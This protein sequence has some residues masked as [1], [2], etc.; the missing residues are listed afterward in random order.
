MVVVI[1]IP[2]PPYGVTSKGILKLLVEAVYTPAALLF[3]KKL[4]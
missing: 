2:L 4:S 3:D 1:E